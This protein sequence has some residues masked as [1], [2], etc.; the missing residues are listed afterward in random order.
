V[1]IQDHHRPYISWQEYLD[2][3][4]I[5]SQNQTNKPEQLLPNI[6][7]EGQALL[8]A[9]FCAVVAAA[10]SHLATGATEEF[11]QSTNVPRAIRTRFA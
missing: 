4:Q 1:L 8:Q 7:R 11:I 6:A 2:N 9:C 5:L 3:Q 10:D